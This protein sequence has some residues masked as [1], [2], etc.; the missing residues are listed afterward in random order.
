MTHSPRLAAR[1]PLPTY[2][3]Y[4]VIFN[5][6]IAALLA[7][8]GFGGGFGVNLVYSQCIG[9][10]ASLL[11]FGTRRLLWPNRSAP[12]AFLLPFV[13]AFLLLAWFGGT[14]LAALLLGHPWPVQGYLTSLVITAVAGFV[15]VLYFWER[16]KMAGLETEAAQ[17]KS[18]VETIERQ[19]AQARL[20][21]LQA[22]IEPHFLFNTL[23]NL[24]ALIGAEPARAQAM[25]SHLNGF[26][27]ASLSAARK[28][29]NTLAEE[30]ALLRDY[31]ELL[32][33]RMGARLAFRLDLPQ[34]LA[35]TQV[36]P[37]L[38][39]PLVENA[40]KH[41]LEPKV[42]GGEVTV[43][44]RRDGAHMVL[45]VADNGLGFAAAA[46][47]GT[48]V[49]LAHLRERLAAIYGAGASLV[50]AEN[51]QGG[52]SVTLNLPLPA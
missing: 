34:E 41:G 30:F 32:S 24:H 48:N 49:G 37:M 51:A 36:P 47:S 12:I 11:S 16:E 14:W 38:L 8:V 15:A 39:Q 2:I 19:A 28:D 26:L 20:A 22:Q 40:V 3:L 10:P 13:I 50:I 42:E 52:V 27:R 4:S 6:V 45:Q 44:A 29:R 7:A 23:A 31:L 17:Q 21:L 5:T 46:T 25:L 18:R 9:L 33:I 1:T 43:I 35:Q